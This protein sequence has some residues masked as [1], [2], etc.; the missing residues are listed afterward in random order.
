MLTC[1]QISKTLS[2]SDYDQLPPVKKFCL[3][4]HVA[5]CMFCGQFNRQVMDSQDMCRHYKQH[6]HHLEHQRPK[7][8]ADQ[9]AQLKACLSN[10]SGTDES[11]SVASNAKDQP[12]S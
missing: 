10:P 2:S 9:K 3:K 4:L 1:K 5:L 8:N 6:E 11:S 7:L 12:K